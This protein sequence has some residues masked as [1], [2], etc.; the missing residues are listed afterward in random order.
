MPFLNHLFLLWNHIAASMIG[1]T[2][3]GSQL[4]ELKS[5]VEV[6]GYGGAEI[7]LEALKIFFFY[8]IIFM[9]SFT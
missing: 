8:V 9:E 2:M 4:I 6:Q 3:R 5:Y 7:S 1:G